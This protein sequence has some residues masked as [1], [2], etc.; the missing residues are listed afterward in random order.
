MAFMQLVR[1]IALEAVDDAPPLD[2]RT[3]ASSEIAGGGSARRTLCSPGY[4]VRDQPTSQPAERPILD[5]PGG[6]GEDEYLVVNTDFLPDTRLS[7]NDNAR[8]PG[9]SA[10]FYDKW[11]LISVRWKSRNASMHPML[12]GNERGLQDIA[13]G[14]SAD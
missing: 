5:R 10:A 1:G 2:G 7:L 8:I 12:T 13:D 3:L 4:P 6:P 14:S 11:H 9:A